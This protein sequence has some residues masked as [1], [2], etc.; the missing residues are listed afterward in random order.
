MR[1]VNVWD[2]VWVATRHQSYRSL[3]QAV[4]EHCDVI[5]RPGAG[6]LYA[7]LLTATARDAA[8]T[9][10]V[11]A[12]AWDIRRTTVHTPKGDLSQDYWESKSGHLPLT[13]KYFVSAP[14]DA[15]RVLS[16]QYERPAIDLT[17]YFRL[18]EKWRWCSRWRWL[19]GCSGS[20]PP[21]GRMRFAVGARCPASAPSCTRIPACR[22]RPR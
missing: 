14:E 5:V 3:I 18:A 11:D 8:E 13:K 19:S 6:D 4:I 9:T 20:M 1:G 12:G 15:G 22:F 2:D 21:A 10:V 17:E 7:P 16:L